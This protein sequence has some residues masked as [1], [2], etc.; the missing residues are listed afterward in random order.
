MVTLGLVHTNDIVV[1]IFEIHSMT[2]HV[3]GL[4][5]ENC[6]LCILHVTLVSICMIMVPYAYWMIHWLVHDNCTICILHVTG[7]VH[8]IY[9]IIIHFASYG[10]STHNIYHM[11]IPCYKFFLI[12]LIVTVDKKHYCYSTYSSRLCFQTTVVSA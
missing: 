11:H 2:L 9:T 6:T 5:H 12:L 1:S 8:E 3:S 4:V 10:V 7:L